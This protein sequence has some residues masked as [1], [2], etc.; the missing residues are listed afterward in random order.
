MT[1]MEEATVENISVRLPPEI[2][3]KLGLEARKLALETGEVVT[4][5]DMIRAC[6]G[7]KFPQVSTRVRREAAA[8]VALREEVA[9]LSERNASL[10]REIAGL[11]KTLVELFPTLATKVQVK[12]LTDVLETIFQAQQGS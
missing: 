4:V 11:A 2:C 6:I 12:K 7:E 8:L 1:A 10:E 9:T 3:K 5:S